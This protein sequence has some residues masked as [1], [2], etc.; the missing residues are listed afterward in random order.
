MSNKDS[1]AAAPPPFL[2]KTYD[3][4]DDSSTDNIVSWGADGTSFIVWKHPEFARDL[5]PK[6]FKHNNFS[7]FV[8]QLNT[9]GFRKVDPDR[10]EFANENFIRGRRD[11]L[12]EIH[13]RK[14][15]AGPS[16]PA[17]HPSHSSTAQ[18]NGHHVPANGV[19]PHNT[20]VPAHAAV[21]VG[22]YGG[23]QQELEGL[24]RDKNVLMMELVRMR[25]AQSSADDKIRDLQDRLSITEQRQ[26]SLINF[27][28]TA[29]K[30]PRILQRLLTSISTA[31]VQRIGPP[32]SRK[33]RR[34]RGAEAPATVADIHESLDYELDMLDP[35]SPEL[36]P[37]TGIPIGLSDDIP[38]RPSDSGN[39][40]GVSSTSGDDGNTCNAAQ[41]Q[42]V[43]YNP[44]K[45]HAAEL[46]EMFLHQVA[47]PIIATTTTNGR[48][49][50]GGPST[51]THTAHP[52][53]SLGSGGGAIPTEDHMLP[54]VMTQFN[55][56]FDGLQLGAGGLQGRSSVP[57]VTEVQGNSGDSPFNGAALVVP[58]AIIEAAPAERKGVMTN[59][60]GQML[61]P[62]TSAIMCPPTS[63]IMHGGISGLP[64]LSTQLQQDSPA[65]SPPE[66]LDISALVPDAVVPDVPDTVMGS[67]QGTAPMVVTTPS[68]AEQIPEDLINL[69]NMTSGDLLLN[70]LLFRDDDWAHIMSPL[71]NGPSLGAQDAA[72]AQAVEDA[73]TRMIR[74]GN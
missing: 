22:A 64:V 62:M 38:L 65:A 17:S 23:F 70:E 53:T 69:E 39:G 4:I 71:H 47:G 24:K 16:Q 68:G 10:W 19:L 60:Q 46:A 6:H 43:Q 26:Q 42:L 8:R 13:R 27:F 51:S 49:V 54:E 25:Q 44:S 11:L 29:L 48:S 63:G 56:A 32:T 18:P 12:R 15:A 55:D 40:H 35:D 31:G 50:G 52:S 61:I 58:Q 1:T 72:Q 3:L 33:K 41:Q 73:I 5:L 66:I 28:A 45:A 37:F 20:L 74:A 2:T 59:S 9:Y 30:D 7:S 34:A 21:E 57:V 67:V 14:P 36:D